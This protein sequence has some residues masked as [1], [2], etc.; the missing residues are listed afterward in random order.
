[1]NVTKMKYLTLE[2]ARKMLP[3]WWIE[4][5][6]TTMSIVKHNAFFSFKRLK[7]FLQAS[8]QYVDEENRKD[9]KHVKV[10]CYDK[11]EKDNLIY[12]TI[13]V[14]FKSEEQKKENFWKFSKSFHVK[15]RKTLLNYD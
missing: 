3:K 4:I 14:F 1:M 2:E 9:L 12:I 11:G 8:L 10:K 13:E 5:F 6:D 15:K 7:Q